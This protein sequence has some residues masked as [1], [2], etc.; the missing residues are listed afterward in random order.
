MTASPAPGMPSEEE[1]ARLICGIDPPAIWLDE[2]RAILALIRPAFEA[3]E[4]ELAA[5]HDAY[6]QAA[7]DAVAL[8]R[9]ADAK[10]AQAVVALR[11]VIYETTHLSPR[12]DDG[13]HDCRI[14]AEA[15]RSA[16]AAAVMGEKTLATSKDTP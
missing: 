7:V 12:R 6:Q 16:R 5:T 11:V 4:R 15:L 14:S 2:A 9:D 1:I 8:Y 13:S 10:L 3:K